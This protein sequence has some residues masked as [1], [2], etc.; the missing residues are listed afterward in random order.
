MK[1][2]GHCKLLL[3]RIFTKYIYRKIFVLV[4]VAPWALYLYS[5]NCEEFLDDGGSLGHMFSQDL[6]ERLRT[7]QTGYKGHV[8]RI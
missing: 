3:Q 4:S 8:T 6:L 7:W 5:N 2:T 1:K